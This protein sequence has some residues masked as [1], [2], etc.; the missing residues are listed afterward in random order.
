MKSIYGKTIIAINQN[1]KKIE[2]ENGFFKLFTSG[3][4]NWE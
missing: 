1:G 3:C 4:I 2:K